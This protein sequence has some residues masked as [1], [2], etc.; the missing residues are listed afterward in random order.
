M[1]LTVSGIQCD[2]CGNIVYSR[3]RH[4]MRS[5]N[6]GDIAIDGGFDYTKVCFRT[7]PPKRVEIQVNATKK[8]LFDDWNNNIN[9][10]GLIENE[11]EK[12]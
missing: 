4:D 9:K 5:C 2:K 12:N 1:T 3:A 8:Q 6:C 11:C 10:F 7:S